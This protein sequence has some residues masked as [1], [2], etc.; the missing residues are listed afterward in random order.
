MASTGQIRSSSV[1]LSFGELSVGKR[2]K[3]V[4]QSGFK[5]VEVRIGDRSPVGQ[6]GNGATKE[7]LRKEAPLKRPAA[8]HASASRSAD[9]GKTISNQ[10]IAPSGTKFSSVSRSGL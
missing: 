1:W 9:P 7:V 5:I 10:S 6:R 8:A 2:A 3:M 4:S